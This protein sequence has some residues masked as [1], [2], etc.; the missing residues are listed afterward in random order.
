MGTAEVL[1]EPSMVP[2]FQG[3]YTSEELPGSDNSHS[4]SVEGPNTVPCSAGDAI[5][6]TLPR[7]DLADV[8]HESYGPANPTD[9]MAIAHL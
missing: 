4:F 1:C 8:K 5:P 6:V 7:P 3:S 2:D 9:H